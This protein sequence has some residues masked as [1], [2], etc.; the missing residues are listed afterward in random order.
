MACKSLYTSDGDLRCLFEKLNQPSDQGAI[1]EREEN[2]VGCNV[3]KMVLDE[4]ALD[5]L[6]SLPCGGVPSA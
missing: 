6:F 2:K 1:V 3:G 5:M 4:L